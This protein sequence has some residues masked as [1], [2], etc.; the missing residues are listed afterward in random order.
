MLFTN[1]LILRPF[2]AQ[3]L[4]GIHDYSSDSVVTEFMTWG[5]NS[6]AQTQE[7]LNLAISR[8]KQ[9]NP[10]VIDFAVL[11]RETDQILGA[12]TVRLSGFKSSIGEIGYCFSRT[13]WGQGIATEA[14][15]AVVAFGFNELMLEKIW[16]SSD[17]QNIGSIR[18]LQ[19]TGLTQEG[20]LRKYI[21]AKGYWRDALLFGLVREDYNKATL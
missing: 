1:R 17:P 9:A 4:Q 12:I 21:Y 10:T 8:S 13:S 16:A 19:K 15:A 14:V 2:V 20:H 6:E 7:F 3:D 11:L 5:P 18:V